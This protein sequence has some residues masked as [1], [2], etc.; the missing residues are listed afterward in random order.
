MAAEE[1]NE[2][3]RSIGGIEDYE[4]PRP[5][6]YLQRLFGLW[7]P[8]R[9]PKILLFHKIFAGLLMAS[10]C[11]CVLYLD[12]IRNN[13]WISIRPLEITNSCCTIIDFICPFAFTVYYFKKGQYDN[14]IS[15]LVENQEDRHW[16]KFYSKVYSALS[17]LLW[18]SILCFL[19][20]FYHWKP[21]LNKT[22]HWPVYTVTTV[23]ITGCWAIWLSVYGY[24]CE[25]HCVEIKRFATNVKETYQSSNRTVTAERQCLNDL[26]EKRFELQDSLERTQS[27][28]NT[29]ISLAVAY[30]VF[31]VIVFSCAY[32]HD[33]FGPS[34]PVYQYLGTLTFDML[35]I[36]IKVFPASK[37]A[38]EAQQVTCQIA[39]QCSP[40]D[41]N[42]EFPKGRLDYFHY[43]AICN[44]DLGFRILGIHITVN[45]AF[46]VI[47]TVVTA[48]VSFTG[49]II[50]RLKHS[51]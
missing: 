17:V 44:Q 5:C 21:F 34:Y 14:F 51:S 48:T 35:S 9:S 36:L 37:V 20:F 6:Y 11:L 29:M 45:I 24:V 38:K 1:A 23:Y 25:A 2:S 50:P 43:A 30:H 13:R 8:L 15:K 40:G 28:F 12:K 39:M 26:L 27:D 18:I 7:H 41:G 49:A 4:L 19:F 16:L 47:V 31:D 3:T 10:S 46:A 32:W 42:H 22:W 33:D